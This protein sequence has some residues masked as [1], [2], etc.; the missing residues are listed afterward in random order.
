MKCSLYI[1]LL[2]AV[3]LLATGFATD[4]TQENVLKFTSE[5]ANQLEATGSPGFLEIAP[6]NLPSS[7]SGDCNHLGWPIATMVDDAIVVMHRRIPGHNPSGAGKPDPS[8]SYGIVLRST[9]GGRT[10]SS[11][12]DLR[13]C[14]LPQDRA[15]GGVVPLSHRAKFDK[16]NKSPLGYKVHLHSIGTTSDNAV[17]AINNH[18]VFRSDDAGQSWRHFS[19]TL[20]DD[21]FHHQ[22]VNLG[23]RI[24]DHPQH[25]L[26]VFGNWFGEVD[27]YHKL[28]NHLVA[29]SSPDGGATWAVEEHD[30]GLPQYEP[31]A[32][33]HDDRLLFVT[34]DQTKVR[35]HQQ[36]SWLPGEPPVVLKTNLEDPR[37][38]DTVDFSFNPVTRRFEI[39][40]SERHH[41]ELWIWSM[42]PADW[43]EGQWRRECRLL[44]TEGKFYSTAD[45]FHPAGAVIDIK[46]GVQHI[47]VYAG[48]P[49]GPAGVFRIT[50]TLDTP[51]LVAELAK[52]VTAAR[53]PNPL[54]P[55]ALSRVPNQVNELKLPYYTFGELP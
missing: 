16:S 29:L 23:P 25:G 17:V 50:R 13:D 42:D 10:W 1:S 35:A 46:R 4:L 44:A 3:A 49:N 45:G 27:S 43:D 6:V 2:I 39:V 26:M 8:M 54:T 22:I 31:A 37:L 33:F 47:F 38:I 21:T 11:P 34:R 30:V 12:F 51:K 52:P 53:V 28:S 18:G 36:M 40:R 32:L 19:A 14:M 9:D 7:S 24:L 15:R 20:R 41:M 48:H 5:A 55:A